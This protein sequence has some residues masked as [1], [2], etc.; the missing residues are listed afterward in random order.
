MSLA[1]KIVKIALSGRLEEIDRFREFPLEV[2]SQQFQYLI[3]NLAE[4]EYGRV[5]RIQ[6]DSTLEYFKENTP[7]ATYETLLNYIEEC[8]SG[9]PGILWTAPIKWFAKSSGTTNDK[10]KFIPVSRES[11]YGCQFQGG[12]DA[13]AF[14]TK[15]Y[16]EHTIFNGKTLTLGGSHAIDRDNPEIRSGDL[17][18]IMI[19]H[20]PFYAHMKRAP[21]TETALIADF[22]TKI[23]RICRET[24]D[25]HI[26]A[27]AGVP[28]WNLVLMNRILEYTGAANILEVWPDMELF[29]HGGVA[30]EP[31][32]EQYE[33]IIPSPAMKYVETYNASEG[34]FAIQDDPASNDMLLM[35]DYGIFYEFLP[36][37]EMDD[38][39]KAVS[40]ADVRAGENYAMIISTSGGLW[41]YLIGDTVTFTSVNP[42]RIRITGR[43]KQFINAFGEEIIVENADGAI[44]KACETTG[45]VISDYTA[46]PVYMDETAK[47][48][49]QWLI[50]FA[51]MPA[52]MELF[53]DT[54][55]RFLQSVNSD[56][57]AKR[58]NNSTLNRP[59]V[60]A[61]KPGVFYEWMRQR[62][63]LG[64]QNKI[65]RLSNDR[66]YV[67][68]LL[69][70]N[71]TIAPCT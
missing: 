24:V 13:L 56:Y 5:H 59:E 2:Q 21:K 38:P 46:A 62:G 9:H 66:K 45:A 48:V 30:F 1:T 18:A 10:S 29:I 63:K 52:D 20:T 4:T 57:E 22:E 42:F 39:S 40:L 3:K 65:P 17:S 6:A 58:R 41:R 61:L 53:T 8:R 47:G 35:L 31:Y 37:K 68:P 55:D 36:V 14:V 43:T 19:Q 71:E 23:Q 54:L 16:P 44:Q 70:I 33:R 69:E 27:F 34:F 50:E 7:V 60:I 51:R 26:T 64:G 15:N 12:R 49:H 32:R 25:Q 67:E 28:S 11:L